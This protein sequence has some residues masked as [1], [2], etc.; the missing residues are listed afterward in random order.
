MR[1]L[2]LAKP[3]E[4]LSSM[5]MPDTT[6]NDPRVLIPDAN[7]RD[8]GG[9]ATRDGK[10]VRN[11]LLFRSGHLHNLAQ[12]DQM[13]LNSLNLQTVIDLRRQTEIAAQPTTPQIGKTE[14]IELSVSNSDNEFA[15]AANSLLDPSSRPID[16]SQIATYFRRIADEGVIRYRP[17]L[18]LA[19]DTSRHPLLFHCTAGKDRTGVVAAFLLRLLD[20][21]PKAVLD[22]YLLSNKI[23]KPWIEAIEA[24][25]RKRIAQ[26]LGISESAVSADQTASSQ[27]LLWC[28]PEYL[29]AVFS[30]IDESWGS[31]DV[32][33]QEG[34]QLDNERLAAF[35]HSLLD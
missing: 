8:L 14:I 16:T 30:G 20:V 33:V 12:P 7:L 1:Y 11:G 27:A 9:L 6:P 29:E 13:T 18:H 23:R 3:L 22:D 24:K 2:A 5:V 19:T 15:I 32:F 28:Q 4:R 21:S 10:Q 25:H 31:W 26:Y 17:V 34:L 35:R